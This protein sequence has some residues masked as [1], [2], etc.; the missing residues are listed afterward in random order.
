MPDSAVATTSTAHHHGHQSPRLQQTISS[1]PDFFLAPPPATKSIKKT[2]PA[3]PAPDIP[4]T[5]NLVILFFLWNIAINF[6]IIKSSEFL[7]SY[8]SFP[9][10]VSFTITG[11][12]SVRRS[13]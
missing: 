8:L 10:C 4:V 11:P 13:S 9:V 2:A 12:L 5:K 1:S 6:Y 7:V 3:S